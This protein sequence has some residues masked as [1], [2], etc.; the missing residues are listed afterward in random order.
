M[1]AAAKAIQAFALP[2]RVRATQQHPRRMT[3]LF[4]RTVADGI[5][6]PPAAP[7]PLDAPPAAPPPTP[8]SPPLG[9]PP[10]PPW[11]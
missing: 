7:P 5:D 6:G 3:H 2:K 4:A 9:P 10:P 8:A 11:R 1:E